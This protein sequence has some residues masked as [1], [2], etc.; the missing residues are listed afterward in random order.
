MIIASY[1]IAVIYP[2]YTEADDRD[3]SHDGQDFRD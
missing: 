2:D 3:E 1:R